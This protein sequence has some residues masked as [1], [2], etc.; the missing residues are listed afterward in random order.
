MNGK[1]AIKVL[2]LAI[3]FAASLIGSVAHAQWSE[4]MWVTPFPGDANQ[5]NEANLAQYCK[6]HMKEWADYRRNKCDARTSIHTRK[7]CFDAANGVAASRQR[8][9]PNAYKEALKAEKADW[10]AQADKRGQLSIAKS[11]VT[12]QR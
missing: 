10:E 9:C 4:P 1:S 11:S 2:V 7:F 5:R 8:N 6:Q 3:C 12:L